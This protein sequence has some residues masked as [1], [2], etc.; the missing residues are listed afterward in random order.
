MIAVVIPTL[1]E[2]KAI[3]DV[4]E[5]FPDSYRDIEIRKY[6]VDGGSIDGTVEKAEKAGAEIINQRLERGKGDGLRQA[7]ENIEADYYLI[8]DGDGSYDPGEFEKI[9]DPLI[10]GKAEH[11][12]GW[13]RNRKPGSI[14]RL[15]LLGNKIFNLLAT[16]TTGRK[17]HDM[18]SGYR[19]F[20]TE[21]LEYTDLTR[22]GFGIETEM[23]FT[24][25]KNGVPLEEVEVSY[26][27]RE[28]ESK[29]DPFSDG[30]RIMNTIIWSVRD[31]N[32]LKFFSIVSAFWI[33]MAV[34]P[35]FLTLRQKLQEGV[36]TNLGPALA[37]SVFL[38]IAVQMMIFGLLADQIKNVERRMR[39]RL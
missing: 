15:N 8:I 31:M 20:S 3:G 36:I 28:G 10:D 22:P 29:L 26:D 7:V 16:L 33:L 27:D 4:I 32:P 23:T 38:I 18:L 30:W 34:Y 11:V 39:N 17:I 1:N 25:L 14:P 6:V 13:R 37:A 5:G 9:V 19:G 21:S 2:E 35:A 12:I 24:A